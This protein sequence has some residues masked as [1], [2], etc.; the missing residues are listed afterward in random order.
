MALINFHYHPE[1]FNLTPG[2]TN[3]FILKTQNVFHSTYWPKST[4]AR[5][6]SQFLFLST[7]TKLTCF[8]RF[9]I[10]PCFP[11]QCVGPHRIAPYKIQSR[12][13]LI[14][15]LT[16]YHLICSVSTIIYL[17][18]F[19]PTNN[20]TTKSSSQP[21]IAVARESSTYIHP[22]GD[23][24]AKDQECHSTLTPVASHSYHLYPLP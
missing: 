17:Q 4:I 16:R 1:L 19:K 3:I 8:I 11:R 20:S 21:V 23:L 22:E 2:T 24:K 15:P 7:P 18:I 6:I 5:W 12:E 14:I 10:Q 13:Q 9:I